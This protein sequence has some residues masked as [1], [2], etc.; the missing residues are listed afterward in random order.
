MSESWSHLTQNPLSTTP[1]FLGEIYNG[2]TYEIKSESAMSAANSGSESDD[3]TFKGYLPGESWWAHCRRT[4]TRCTIWVTIGVFLL[5]ISLGTVLILMATNVIYIPPRNPLAHLRVKE[6]PTEPIPQLRSRALMN[7]T[8]INTAVLLT[9]TTGPLPTGKLYSIAN[10]TVTVRKHGF[11]TR[12]RPS[13]TA[14]NSQ[15]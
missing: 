12:I 7:Q 6:D 1:G 11:V 10:D 2:E 15:L 3:K 9:G 4:T 8:Q 13:P 14:L 5:V